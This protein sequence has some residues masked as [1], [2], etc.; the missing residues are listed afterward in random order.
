[1]TVGVCIATL[2]RLMVVPESR[3]LDVKDLVERRQ[4]LAGSIPVSALS[5]LPGVVDSGEVTYRLRF[6]RDAQEIPV[7]NGGYEVSLNVL[8]QRCMQP[9]SVKLA[10]DLCLGI[11]VGEEAQQVPGDAYDPLVTADGK[12]SVAGILQDEIILALPISPMHE[13]SDC[14]AGEMVEKIKP[15]RQNPFSVLKDLKIE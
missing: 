6:G 7:L 8:C 2:A 11:V 12:I 9:M 5:D 14:P 1:M 15:K 3:L 13:A 10:Q 4:E